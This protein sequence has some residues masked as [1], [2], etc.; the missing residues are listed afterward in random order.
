MP[1]NGTDNYIDPTKKYS[2]TYS[3][4]TFLDIVET[5]C[6][7]YKKVLKQ[8]KDNND[9]YTG[10][11]ILDYRNNKEEDDVSDFYILKIFDSWNNV[12]DLLPIQEYHHRN[13]NINNDIKSLY[14]ILKEISKISEKDIDK[15][16]VN[17]FNNYRKT[18]KE[19]NIPGWRSFSKNIVG[20]NKWKECVKEVKRYEESL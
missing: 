4:N 6:R 9:H 19:K 14:N 11:S 17:D 3:D 12:L 16:G 15:I 1:I 18:N 20:N 13:N 2:D 5:I 8:R 10:F 7:V